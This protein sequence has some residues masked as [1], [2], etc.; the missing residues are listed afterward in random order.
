[1]RKSSEC[2]GMPSAVSGLSLIGR[3]RGAKAD[4]ASKM[5]GGTVREEMWLILNGAELGSAARNGERST[6][7]GVPGSVAGGGDAA[8][9][10]AAASR[11]ATQAA[12]RFVDEAIIGAPCG[13]ARLGSG[14]QRSFRAPRELGG[15]DVHVAP[16]VAH[17][18]VAV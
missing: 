10:H 4:G 16:E 15:V 7:W 12:Q 8:A 14:Q 18:D 6:L 5:C 1:M 13:P 17:E 2:C 11:P 9:T 3:A